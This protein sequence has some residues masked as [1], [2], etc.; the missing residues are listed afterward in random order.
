MSKID[1]FTAIDSAIVMAI[2]QGA[3]TFAALCRH[4]EVMPTAEAMASR[5]SCGD[6]VIDG[7]LQSLKRAGAIR[8]VNRL[9][10]VA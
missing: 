3:Q 9:W 8:Y 2:G 5:Q 7:R 10:E 6:R 1:R 4:P